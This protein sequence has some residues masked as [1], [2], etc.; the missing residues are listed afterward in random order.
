MNRQQ[1]RRYFQRTAD[2]TKQAAERDAL[3]ARFKGE[4]DVLTD[5]EVTR[6]LTLEAMFAGGVVSLLDTD[7]QKARWIDIRRA[8]R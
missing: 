4:G 5:R 7:E 2:L 6:L 3:V 1:Q 8:A